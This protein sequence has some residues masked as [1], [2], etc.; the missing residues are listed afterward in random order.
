MVKT[1]V[2]GDCHGLKNELYSILDS[3]QSDITEVIQVGDLGIGFGQSDYWHEDLDQKLTSVNGS[4]IR[5]NHDNPSTCKEF[6]SWIPDGTIQNDWMFIGGAWSIDYQLRTPG[7]SW[8]DNEELSSYELETIISV[9]ELINPRVMITHDIPSSVSNSLFFREGRPY[10]GRKIYKTRTAEALE[11]MFR[12]HKPDL[13]L[14][15][16]WHFDVDETI[17]KT[18]FVC[19]NELSYVDVNRETL[20]LEFPSYWRPLND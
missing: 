19:L 20:E 10:A 2:I 6:K 3:V 14:F 17:D 7:I 12:I 5:G 13:W 1:R 8:W 9:Y 4:F 18:R 16:H 11:A 15:G